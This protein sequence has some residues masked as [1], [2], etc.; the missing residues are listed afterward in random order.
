ME[1][2][3]LLAR[4]KQLVRL[5]AIWCFALGGRFSA[6]EGSLLKKSLA[7]PINKGECIASALL[8]KLNQLAKEQS[9]PKRD[10]QNTRKKPKRGRHGLCWEW[11]PSPAPL[12]E[13]AFEI[14]SC[15]DY[16]GLTIDSPEPP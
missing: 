14:L 3:E 6:N 11:P 2:D 9:P 10:G 15:R 7:N 16:L 13:Q 12:L 4:C 8:S 1:P 5:H